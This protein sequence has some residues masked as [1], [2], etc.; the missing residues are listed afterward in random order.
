MLL[1]LD[2]PHEREGGV[3]PKGLRRIRAPSFCMKTPKYSSCRHP[4]T[5]K[6]FSPSSQRKACCNESQ[7]FSPRPLFNVPSDLRYKSDFIS[8]KQSLGLTSTRKELLPNSTSLLTLMSR[9]L[10]DI[11]V[12]SDHLDHAFHL[13]FR[14][15]GWWP[16]LEDACESWLPAAVHRSNSTADEEEPLAADQGDAIHPFGDAADA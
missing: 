14:R 4:S 6:L 7:V 12:A 11:A 15:G 5:T 2:V 1:S 13:R 9:C 10:W 3:S 16:Q 8:S